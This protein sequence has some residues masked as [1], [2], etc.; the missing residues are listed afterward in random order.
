[1]RCAL[2]VATATAVALVTANARPAA[3][4]STAIIHLLGTLLVQSARQAV[5]MEI[6]VAAVVTLALVLGDARKSAVNAVVGE[7]GTS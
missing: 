6:I 7:A 3:I 2:G 4:T 1:M 5:A